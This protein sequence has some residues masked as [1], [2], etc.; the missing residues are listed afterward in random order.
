VQ[1]ADG[2]WLAFQEYFVTRGHQDEVTAIEYVGT[3]DAAPAPGVLAAIRSA[4]LVV[5]APSNPPLSIWPILAVPGIRDALTAASCVVAVSPLFGG[6][7]L[8]GPADR[9]LVSLGLPSGTPGILKA[10]DGLI[11]T[12]VVD[13]GDSEDVSLSTDSTRVLATD[14]RMTT[15]E[16][17]SAFGSWL[18]DTM[19][20]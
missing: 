1:I 10:Y 9:V 12:L 16:Q 15:R 4:D 19:S 20:A 7:A 6:K 2:S 13:N 18:M 8:K 5:V 11:D 3:A 17:G 14:T